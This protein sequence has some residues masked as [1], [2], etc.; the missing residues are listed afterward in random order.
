MCIVGGRSVYADE[1]QLVIIG[2]SRTEDLHAAVGDAGCIWAH[3]VGEGLYWMRDVAVPEVD[4]YIGSNSA[5]VILMG[6]ND[7]GYTGTAYE[8]VSYINARA[9]DW[10]ARGAVTYYFSVCPINESIYRGNDVTNA[11]IIEWNN[12][13]QNGLSEDVIYVDVYNDIMEVMDT[14]DGMHY[15]RSTSTR[16][17]ELITEAVANT[18]QDPG[19]LT[20]PTLTYDRVNVWIDTKNGR[21]HYDENG[22]LD[23]GLTE[24]DGDWYYFNNFGYMETGLVDMSGTVSMFGPDGKR[25]YGLVEEGGR[26]R[27]FDKDGIMQTGLVEDQGTWYYFDKNGVGADQTAKVDGKLCVFKGGRMQ[28]GLIWVDDHLYFSE[29]DGALVTGWKEID[30]KTYYFEKDGAVI[31]KWR[32]LTSGE[33]QGTYYFDEDGTMVTG[34]KTI[35]DETYHF[36]KD[37]KQTVGWITEKDKKYYYYG[38]PTATKARGLVAIEGTTYYFA[39]DGDHELLSGWVEGAG[40]LYYASSDGSVLTG[41]HLDIDNDI[42]LFG[43]NGVLLWSCT[44]GIAIFIGAMIVGAIVAG[45]A[46]LILLLKKKHKE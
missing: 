11:D 2:D 43:S 42:Y 21:L 8:Y 14:P 4:E 31:G 22:E 3:K 35:D 33:E 28:T 17:F 41:L 36:E 15:Q 45:A 27:Y 13:M 26:L 40:G 30:G 5:V 29:D 46:I 18:P 44:R 23:I 25:L 10:A 7:A 24:I 9:A 20:M 39:E 19:V 32:T 16:W 6:V 37:G 38:E 1:R 34:W 12:I